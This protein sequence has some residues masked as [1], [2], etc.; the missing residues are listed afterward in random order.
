[1]AE[2]TL[3]EERRQG[4]RGWNTNRLKRLGDN[5][6]LKSRNWN[7]P[8]TLSAA[9]GKTS[10]V[11]RR[12]SFVGQHSTG[13]TLRARG[14]GTIALLGNL[15]AEGNFLFTEDVP[16]KGDARSS[17]MSSLINE[18]QADAKRRC[19]EGRYALW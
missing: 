2:K 18:A 14:G 12:L 10:V 8:S 5:Q 9:K 3:V 7:S 15:V 11:R 19:L 4:W 16:M 13:A 17:P 1:M 6:F